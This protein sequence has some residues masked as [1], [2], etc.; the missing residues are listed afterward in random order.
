MN[1][2][3]LAWGHLDVLASLPTLTLE[4]SEIFNVIFAPHRSRSFIRFPPLPPPIW[5][6]LVRNEGSLD[7]LLRMHC[8]FGEYRCGGGGSGMSKRSS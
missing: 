2:I 4:V 5:F 6:H 8:S 1:A 7:F 3:T